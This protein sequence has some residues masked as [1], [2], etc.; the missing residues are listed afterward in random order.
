MKKFLKCSELYKY[1]EAFILS[2]KSTFFRYTN[3][4]QY[5]SNIKNTYK[6]P[7]PKLLILF[8]LH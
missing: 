4:F 1:I 7:I 8:D 6:L 2:I 5:F 3:M